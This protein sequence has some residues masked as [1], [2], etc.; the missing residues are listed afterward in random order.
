MWL[1]GQIMTE[2]VKHTAS[3]EVKKL[4]GTMWS[5]ILFAIIVGFASQSFLWGFATLAGCFYLIYLVNL[6]TNEIIAAI[7]EKSQQS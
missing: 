6:A 1:G 7:R 2:S 4:D 3:A 5:M